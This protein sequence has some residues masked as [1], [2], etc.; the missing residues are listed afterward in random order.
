MFKRRGCA[1]AAALAFI[2]AIA[3][4]Q[5]GP[6]TI[7]PANVNLTGGTITSLATVSSAP[8]VTHPSGLTPLFGNS[9]LSTDTVTGATNQGLYIDRVMQSLAVGTGSITGA[10]HHIGAFGE[11]TWA[12]TGTAALQI[13][14]E[15]VSQITNGGIVTNSA[16]VLAHMNSNNGVMTEH[17]GFRVLFDTNTGSVGTHNGFKC[18]VATLGTVGQANCFNNTDPAEDVR[19][20]GKYFNSL[21]QEISNSRP[22][23]IAARYYF[24]VMPAA[25]SAGATINTARSFVW[26]TP[27]LVPERTTYTK[28]GFQVVTVAAASSCAV[29]IYKQLGGQPVGAPLVQSAALPTT[30]TGAQEATIS[31]QLDAG[32][33]MT[34]VNCSSDSVGVAAYTEN[35]LAGAFGAG[36]ATGFETTPV[37]GATTYGTFLSNPTLGFLADTSL[38]PLIWLRK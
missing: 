5:P 26:Y 9:D 17:N 8:Q 16:D 11:A 28:I 3:F 10:G 14:V 19:N 31:L 20:S 2:P 1:V 21:S 13:G 25:A 24:G 32:L 35:S 27:M 34:G 38:A 15:G 6:L 12:S 23:V 22:G 7:N 4:A 29:V 30:A 33:Y 18:D 36:T 37:S